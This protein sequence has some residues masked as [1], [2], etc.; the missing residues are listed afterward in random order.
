MTTNHCSPELPEELENEVEDSSAAR[1]LVRGL[2]IAIEGPPGQGDPLP[3]M[4]TSRFSPTLLLKGPSRALDGRSWAW[5][6]PPAHWFNCGFGSGQN[7]L[8]TKWRRAV[9]R[10][11]YTNC[12]INFTTSVKISTWSVRKF[13]R[14]IDFCDVTTRKFC[15]ECLENHQ[16]SGNWT[17]C[18]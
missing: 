3:K 14:Y 13:P 8:I 11:S 9:P 2:K 18:K 1:L 15:A 10:L 5:D 6:G 4:K 7:L 17:I 12:D 16:I